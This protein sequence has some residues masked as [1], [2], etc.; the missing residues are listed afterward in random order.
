MQSNEVVTS[1]GIS[2]PILKSKL[3]MWIGE[4]EWECEWEQC[5]RGGKWPR[6]LEQTLGFKGVGGAIGREDTKE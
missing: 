6:L 4:W 5:P 2:Q 3:R 1:S